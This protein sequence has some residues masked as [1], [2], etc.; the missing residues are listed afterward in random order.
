MIII[1][2]TMVLGSFDRALNGIDIVDYLTIRGY[3]QDDKLHPNPYKK[4]AQEGGQEKL[5]QSNADITI[6][7]GMRGG[8][9]SYALLMDALND[10]QRKGFRAIIMRKEINDLSDL[11]DT[12]RDIYT[13]FGEYNRSKGDM[14]WNFNNGGW[15]TFGYYGDSLDDFM[16]RY[17]GKQFSYIGIDEITH[18]EYAKF[19]YISTDNRNA[20]FI[21]NRIIGSCNPDPDSWVAKFISWWIGDDGLPILERDGVV[22]YCFMDGDDVDS[23]YWGSTREEVYEMCKS[24]IDR[25]SSG[26][27]E[28]GDP[29]D[30]FIHSVCFI[31]GKL[32]DNYQLLR[33]DPS[34]LANLAN[35][36]EERRARDLEGNW[37]YKEVGEDIIK[38]NN[39]EDFFDNPMQGVEGKVH[40]SCDIALEGG[41]N[42]VMVKW[43]NNL[44]HIDDI[45]VCNL[46]G[47]QTV[48]V[49]K[50]KLDEWGVPET[51]FTYDLN[52]LGQWFKGDG[53]YFPR[54][55]PFCNTG[56]VDP[57]LKYVYKDLKSQA[58]YILAQRILAKEI[59]INPNLLDRKYSGSGYK[60]VKLRDILM[61]ERKVLRQDKDDTDRG[62]SLPKK[63]VMKALIGHSPDFIEAIL[64]AMIFLIKKKDKKIKG[65][66]LL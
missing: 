50:A 63:K 18:M 52:G 2:L 64:M 42:L 13:E 31:I 30:I 14:T 66:G 32:K 21:R 47:K 8:G 33:S 45:F 49:V 19:K 1:Y 60:N 28:F 53:G 54:A 39:L 24:T 15:L 55:V 3:R 57:K 12:S 34:Y 48:N 59:S 38:I 7:G 17:Q 11:I 58:A 62:F 65:I 43:T 29:K 5:L 37:K 25:I 46:G 20:F 6:Y 35:Q 10:C 56:A 23:I 16:V 44:C 9:K 51:N 22:R 26:Y 40:A 41:D 27:E 4:I 36:S 61:H